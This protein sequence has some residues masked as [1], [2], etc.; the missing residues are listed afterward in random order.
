MEKK[1]IPSPFSPSHS[2]PYASVLLIVILIFIA[3][4]LASWHCVGIFSL[5]RQSHRRMRKWSFLFPLCVQESQLPRV[6]QGT[7]IVSVLFNYQVSGKMSLLHRTQA[8]RR[9]KQFSEG[10]LELLQTLSSSAPAVHQPTVSARLQLALGSRSLA[11]RTPQTT[12]L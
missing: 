12:W 9:S 7:L 2:T 3:F 6:E 8:G 11:L 1:P 4:I 5:Q 10:Y